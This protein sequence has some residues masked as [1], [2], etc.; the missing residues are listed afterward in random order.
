MVNV[1]LNTLRVVKSKNERNKSS[2]RSR[3]KHILPVRLISLTLQ[4]E[5]IESGCLTDKKPCVCFL[6]E[7]NESCINALDEGASYVALYMYTYT[8]K[9]DDH[10][11]I[12]PC[13]C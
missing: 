2:K 7:P 9:S 10:I 5:D 13:R 4:V 6:T 8:L 12:L 3:C 1:P 11:P